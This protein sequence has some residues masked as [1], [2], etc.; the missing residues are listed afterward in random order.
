MIKINDNQRI[1]FI[2]DSITDVN[3]NRSQCIKIR[4]NRVYPLQVAK[5]LKENHKG[6]KFFYKGIAS[7]RAFHVY[8]RLTT[9]CIKL[10]PDLIVMLIGVNDAWDAYLSTDGGASLVRPIEP[11]LKEI[12]RR[13]KAE[14]PKATLIVLTPFMTSSMDEKEPFRK[15]VSEY[16][17]RIT[18]LA[19]RNADEIINLLNV[20]EN[21][22]KTN[23][24]KDLAIDAV[25]PT[26]LGHQLIANEILKIID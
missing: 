19:T 9:D 3:F 17:E 5:K 14:L 4:G 10:K 13:I 7:N 16:N 22:E 2:G 11:H 1:L 25:H 21:A 12:Y 6:L 8:D 18:K 20:F 24:P 26:N 15:Y 23:Q